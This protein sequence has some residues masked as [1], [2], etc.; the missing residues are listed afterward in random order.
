MEILKNLFEGFPGLWGGGVAHSVMILA[1]VITLG[2]ILGRVKVKGVSLGLTWILFIGILFAHFSLNLDEHLLHFMKEFGLI[3]FVYSVGLQIGPGFFTSFSKGGM[4]L[5]LMA[6]FSVL[7]SVGMAAVL[8]VTTDTDVPTMAGILSGAVTNTP[9]LGAAQQA[10]SDLRGIDDSSI[11]MGYAVSY[12]IGVLGLMLSCLFL[13]YAMRINKS[14]ENVDAQRGLGRLEKMTVRPFTVKVENASFDGLTVKDMKKLVKREY[15]IS[16]MMGKDHTESDSVVNG[17]TVIHVGDLLHLVA[18]PT[19]V[20][21][22]TAFVGKAVDVDWTEYDNAL[23]A[24]QMLV[25]RNSVNGK[26]IGDLSPRTNY[27]VNVTRVMRSGIELIP[28]SS[29]KLQVGDRITVVGTE[30]GL[31]QVERKVGNQSRKLNDPN[32]LPIFLGIALG[33]VL[34]NVPFYFPGISQ[35]LRLGLTGGP[36]V[37]AILIGYFGPKHHLVTYNTISA[38]LML[39]EVGLCLFLAC[40]GLSSGKDFFNIVFTQQG[41]HWLLWGAMITIVPTIV[42]GLIGR[43]ILHLNFYT[44]LGMLAGINTNPPALAYARELTSA[45]SPSVSY[46]AV[47]PFAMFLRVVAIQLFIFILG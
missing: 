3:L 7:L 34:A 19:D 9:A 41:M 23:V 21:A 35:S 17:A 20:E 22:I 2:L 4:A 24:R 36:L 15:V 27:G 25:T 1:I 33:C 5:N 10:Y 32:T 44:L 31:A 11:L 18:S 47:F 8:L 13:Q 12:P 40:V 43:Y 39:R 29:L 38:N 28:S 14:H 26:T 6:L 30:V 37:I 42:C 16:R 46:S 45:D